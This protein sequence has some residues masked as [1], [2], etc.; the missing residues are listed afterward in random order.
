MYKKSVYFVCIIEFFTNMKMALC[1]APVNRGCRQKVHKSFSQCLN[2]ITCAVCGDYLQTN[3]LYCEL[4]CSHIYHSSC[5]QPW[6]KV[7]DSCP[8][9]R[10][11]I[12]CTNHR[13]HS[14]SVLRAVVYQQDMTIADLRNKN[15]EMTDKIIGL[16]M[17]QAELN[18]QIAAQQLMFHISRPI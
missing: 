8:Q 2:H 1:S 18:I 11:K 16:E 3:S 7:N 5:V 6:K 15:Q 9:C 4:K 13:K 12:E 14:A 17:L 10:A